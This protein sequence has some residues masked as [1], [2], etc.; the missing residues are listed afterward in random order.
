MSEVCLYSTNKTKETLLNVWCAFPAVYN[1]GMSALGYLTV[2]KYI[3]SVDGILVQ[4]PLPIG[5]DEGKIIKD[6]LIN[7]IRRGNN[8]PRLILDNGL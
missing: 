4:L 8:N 7:Q 1:F 2:A 3:D 6:D 5:F